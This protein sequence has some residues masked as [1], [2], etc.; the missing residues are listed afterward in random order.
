M[1]ALYYQRYTNGGILFLISG[2]MLMIHSSLAHHIEL[3]VDLC[4]SR[5]MILTMIMRGGDLRASDSGS[6]DGRVHW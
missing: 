3:E 4:G 2:D 1:V 6:D 5:S